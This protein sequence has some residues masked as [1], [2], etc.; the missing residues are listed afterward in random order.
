M[1][2][3]DVFCPLVLAV[4]L[5]ASPLTADDADDLYNEIKEA[6]D[7]KISRTG[8]SNDEYRRE[9]VKLLAGI[10]TRCE[11]YKK[12]YPA[13]ANMSDVL[14]E[15]AK[16]YFYLSRFK[17]P[18][19]ETLDKGAAI[20]RE[21]VKL[22]PTAEAAAKA[23]GLLVQYNR[24]YGRMDEAL[25]EAQAIAT[26]FAET[27]YAALALFYIGD[28]YDRMGKE[29]EAVA[30]YEKLVK[31]YKDERYDQRY[32]AR[33][34]GI[35]L[36]KRLKGSVVELQFTSTKDQAIDIKDYRGKVVL[37]DFWAAW[38]P[39]CVASMPTL[40]GTERLLH[41]RGFRI[42]GISLDSDEAAMDALIAKM[43]M[44][45]PQYFDGKKWGNLIARK[46][47]ITAIPMTILV[48]RTGKVQ[49]IGLQGRQ[50]Q[51]A[52]RKLLDEKTP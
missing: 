2:H 33:A 35:L 28:T 51:A 36:F 39:P 30:A 15:Q 22:N 5:V 52:I 46:F 29:K 42:I 7:L 8:K 10:I 31:E 47:G 23:R 14:Y 38:C 13:G 32:V 17:S 27:D 19:R 12:R 50:L 24:M 48:D 41:D 49:E 26:D 25:K 21:A 4:F 9:V 18:A 45:W 3:A 44:S 6:G 43:G 11:T 34:E 20:A 37:I 16:A 40:V 1:R